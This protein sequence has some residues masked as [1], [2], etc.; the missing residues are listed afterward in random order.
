MAAGT[1]VSTEAIRLSL[2][3][4]MYGFDTCNDHTGNPFDGPIVLPND[5]AKVLLFTRQGTNT[6][7]GL[8]LSLADVLAPLFQLLQKK[9]L[10]GHSCEVSKKQQ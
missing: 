4:H 1:V 3:Q 2:A 5:V 8:S 7:A 6:S 10:D 9:L